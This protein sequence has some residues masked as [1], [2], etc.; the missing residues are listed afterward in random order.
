MVWR[1]LLFFLLFLSGCGPTIKQAGLES[2]APE[3]VLSVEAL[4]VSV[5]TPGKAIETFTDGW[6]YTRLPGLARA[7]RLQVPSR[8]KV[9]YLVVKTY[10]V[11]PATHMHFGLYT[12]WP[13]E[14]P[15]MAPVRVL[16]PRPDGEMEQLLDSSDFELNSN[17]RI[18]HVLGIPGPAGATWKQAALRMEP[19]DAQTLLIAVN[20][21]L[22]GER[23][24]LPAAYWP[25]RGSAGGVPLF[26]GG[27]PII[28]PVPNMPRPRVEMFFGRVGLVQ[29]DLVSPKALLATAAGPKN[30]WEG[31]ERFKGGS[32]LKGE[33]M[34]IRLPAGEFTRLEDRDREYLRWRFYQQLSDGS[35]LRLIAAD[36]LAAGIHIPDQVFQAVLDD[37]ESNIENLDVKREQPELAGGGSCMKFRAHGLLKKAYHLPWQSIDLACFLETPGASRSPRVVRVGGGF[38]AA[39][40]HVSSAGDLAPVKALVRS[41]RFLKP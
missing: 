40:G 7:M 2:P 21:A 25:F 29:I 23:E 30:K 36:V 16:R 38:V 1:W 12:H 5:I 17:M 4:P 41:L 24:W 14:Q 34:A 26:I 9:M 28:V 8:D 11:S 18:I 6:P 22:V 35:E 15:W 37:L 39:P 3:K 10:A 20:E 19:G 13:L 33:S 31:G 32:E 27:M